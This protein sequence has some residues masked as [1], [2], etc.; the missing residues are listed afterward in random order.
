MPAIQKAVSGEVH[1]AELRKVGAG[2]SGNVDLGNARLVDAGEDF[3]AIHGA[4]GD[5]DVFVSGVVD[6]V[7]M[8][9]LTGGVVEGG[10]RVGARVSGARESRIGRGAYSKGECGG[11]RE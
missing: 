7:T 8:M 3:D 9:R 1:D 10:D 4:I 2:G 5:E 6:D 11:V